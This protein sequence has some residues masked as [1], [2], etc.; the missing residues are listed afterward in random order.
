MRGEERSSRL[1]CV[2]KCSTNNCFLK[3]FVVRKCLIKLVPSAWNE[4]EIVMWH[5]D[6]RNLDGEL[7]VDK[8]IEVYNLRRDYDKW[9]VRLEVRL[10]NN[11]LIYDDK[12]I[13]LVLRKFTNG[14]W[15]KLMDSDKLYEIINGIIKDTEIMVCYS[16]N[17]NKSSISLE[18]KCYKKVRLLHDDGG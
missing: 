18:E 14:D 2:D 12:I 7:W 4:R 1:Y 9:K 15:T 17:N 5:C 6:E 3:F 11:H 16:N 10:S 8:E 13:D